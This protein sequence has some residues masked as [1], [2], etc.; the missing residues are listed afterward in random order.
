M[1]SLFHSQ[2]RYAAMLTFI[3][4][5]L[6]AC[7][8]VAPDNSMRSVQ[9]TTQP[10]LGKQVEW[11]Q[12]PQ[13]QALVTARV[14]ELLQPTLSL[15]NA[16]QIALLNNQ[17]LQA[18]F[19]QLG[20]SQ[21]DLV[22]TTRLPNPRFSMLYAKNGNQFKIEQVLSFN[23]L[24][25]LTMPM[26]KDIGERQLQQT[27]QQVSLD[28]LAL[29]GATRKAYIQALAAEQSLQYMQQVKLA[30]EASA[31]LAQQML[32]AGNFSQ[33]DQAREQV[34]YA[35]VLASHARA[36][37]TA[38]ATREQLIRLLGVWGED[39]QFK[40]AQRLDD[41]PDALV[42][43]QALEATAM[44]QR[45][46][47]QAMQLQMQGLAKNLGLLKATRFINVLEVGPARVLEGQRSEP[48]KNGIDISLELPI[49]DSGAAKVA[50]AEA[51]YRQALNRAAEQA[52]NARSQ[53]RLAYANYRSQYLLAKHYRDEV[54]PLR[55]RIADE[56]LLR[57]N[58]MLLSVFE[59]LS[60]TQTQIASVNAYIQALRDFWL[61][62]ADLDMALVG[63]NPDSLSS[64]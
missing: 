47:L 62:S 37:Q 63:A 17:G 7:A 55:K 53:V 42:D 18:S 22:Q 10:L 23:L 59:L 52:V 8:S 27:Q 16:V 30:A 48:Y 46:D 11:V 9:N 57:Y 28:V 35:E 64:H 54:V 24:A 33:R 43:G 1:F 44:Q 49:F 56:N 58:G 25:L 51:I 19:N 39:T 45:L 2:R 21:A 12:N 26:A 40:L 6:P 4:L 34:F 13:Q 5:L 20:I 3:S 60:D 15:E 41:L 50:R 38:T 61:A 31:D 29:A 14:A 32:A 36:A